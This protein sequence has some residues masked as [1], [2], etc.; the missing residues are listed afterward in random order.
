MRRI[1]HFFAVAAVTL[2]A[3]PA[4]A[5]DSAYTTHDYS[6]CP[7]VVDEDPYQVR[8]CDGLGGIAVN[9]HNE[10]DDAVVDFGAN[11]SSDDWPYEQS[12]VFAGKTV[13]WRGATRAG[14]LVPYAAI[15]RYDLGHSIGGP[16]EPV[17]MIFRLEGRTGSCL[18]ASVDGRR[19]DA[20]AR[21]RRIA[22]R[23]VRTFR[24]GQDMRRARE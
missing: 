14:V 6:T 7:L 3:V 10:D 11:G 1:V 22:D 20:K 8:R 13:E 4:R 9:W 21:A 2:S 24:C 15:V 12:F 17:L 19:A 23:F 5:A 18:A 16:F